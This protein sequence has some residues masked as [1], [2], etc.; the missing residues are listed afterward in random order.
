[1]FQL[2]A[3]LIALL[4]YIFLNERFP[5]QNYLWATLLVAGSVLVSIDEKMSIKTFFKPG[6][7]L[8]LVMQLF[9]AGSNLFIGF[10]LQNINFIQVS[11]WANLIIAISFFPFILI[12]KPKLKYSLKNVSPVLLATTISNFGALFLFKA[13]EEN[14][15]ITSVIALLNAPLVFTISVLASKYLPTLIEHHS[16]KVYVIRG[17]GLIITL[18][19][20]Y[21]IVIS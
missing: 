2:Q 6:I 14:L 10:T 18:I 19:A 17:T 1:L 13:F 12:T 11:F 5:I 20:A 7:I 8:I 4:A 9:H 21:K 3:V 15:T 16:A